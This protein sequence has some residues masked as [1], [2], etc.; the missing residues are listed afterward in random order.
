MSN[1]TTCKCQFARTFKC[2]VPQAWAY[3]EILVQ[4][5]G[6]SSKKDPHKEIKALTWRKKTPIRRNPSPPPR[7]EKKIGGEHLLLPPPPPAGTH[8]PRGWFCEPRYVPR[9]TLC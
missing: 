7:K 3:A 5:G 1:K 2:G 4:G 6:A 9:T 8:D